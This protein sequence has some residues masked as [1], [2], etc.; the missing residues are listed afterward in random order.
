MVLKK[1]SLFVLLIVAN[2]SFASE[3]TNAHSEEHHGEEKSWSE[4]TQEEKKSYIDQ[5]KEHHL[6]DSYNFEI[7]HGVGFSLPVIIWDGELKIFSSSK[8]M[9]GHSHAGYTVDHHGNLVSTEGK[10]KAKMTN[11]F[12]GEED[13]FFDFEFSIS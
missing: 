1:L 10:T 3:P 2:L 13:L 4:K 9:H 12:S 7:T 8:V 6:K 11:L 5:V